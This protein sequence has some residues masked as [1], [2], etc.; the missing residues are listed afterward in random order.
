MK[1]KCNCIGGCAKPI[2][3]EQVM[4]CQDDVMKRPKNIL[5]QPWEIQEYVNQLE[6]QL[7]EANSQLSRCGKKWEKS[8]TNNFSLTKE[9]AK[10][11]E[12]LSI[13]SEDDMYKELQRKFDL[14]KNHPDGMQIDDTQ[15][16]W[17]ECYKWFL[18]VITQAKGEE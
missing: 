3:N 14:G 6:S 5:S 12:G 16:G 17:E 15:I 4:K 7:A 18:K 11:K 13:P 8:I 10:L 9:N 2:L 1:E